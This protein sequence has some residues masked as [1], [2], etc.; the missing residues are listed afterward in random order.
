MKKNETAVFGGGCFWC[1]EALFKSLKGVMSVVPG[2]AGGTLPDP[3]YLEVST[4]NS[5]HAEVVKIEFD[6]EEI[7]YEQLLEIFWATHNPTTLNRQGADVGSQYRSVIFT[8]SAIQTEQA[9]N[10]MKNLAESGELEN[11]IVTSIEPLSV[12]Y[13]AEEYHRDYYDKNADAPYC[14]LVISPKL[15]SLRAKYAHYLK[16]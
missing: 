3:S 4:S 6:P 16:E 10:S 1:T 11:E 2:Y 7:S 5:G 12:F 14:T 15:A 9:R 13:P 8:T